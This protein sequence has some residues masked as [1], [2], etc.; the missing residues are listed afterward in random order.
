MAA[1]VLMFQGTGSD[2]GKSLVVAG[3]C[4]LLA[5]RG[6]SVRPFKP[7][8]MSNNAA[9]TEDGGE[10]G[11][12]QALQARAAR[13]A[14]SVDMNPVLLKPQSEVGAQIVVQGRVFG[15]AR[16]REY[17]S[18]KKELMPYVL[19]SFTKIRAQCDVVLVEGAGSAS[20]VNLRANDIANMGF[21]RAAD[22]PVVVI[23]DIDR[24]GVIASLCGTAAVVA[25]DD[26]KLIV[27]FIVN[28]MRGD[29]SLFSTGMTFVA[30]RTGWAPLGLVPYFRDAH[31]LPAED[32]FGLEVS[33]VR[34]SDNVGRRVRIVVPVLPHIA[35]F[36]DLDPLRLE[37]GV[38]LLLLRNGVPLPVDTDLLILP[39]SK[40]TIADLAALRACGW[41]ADI[42]AYAR[43]G[44]RVL[45]LCGGYQML[46]RS[47]ADPN[48][49][50]GPPGS[51][52]GLGLI[53]VTTELAGD[54]SLVAVKG[55]TV[56]DDI[57]VAGYEMHIGRTTGAGTQRPLL[58]L[59]DGRLDGA[60]SADGRVAGSYLH[61]FFAVDAQRAAWLARLGV[62][63]SSYAYE[64]LV[65][66]TLDAL[67]AHLAAHIDIDKMLSLAR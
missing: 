42:V 41:D 37:P 34:P 23:G 24:G 58:R 1:R 50:E 47:V 6:L 35:N 29:P 3:L 5:I 66:Q 54:K 15:N 56:A 64:E 32:V 7:Q 30:E 8:N 57:A 9:V 60:V 28:K 31:R 55:R 52:D 19:D 16:A 59:D 45:G 33:P 12:A 13:V 18:R 25:P 67:A 44:G 4:R 38:E 39:G 65:E 10:I 21:A 48:G 53:D 27:G 11:R 49:I 36:D 61:G 26:G 2:V 40:A 46:G 17:Q 63:A 20:E 22:V 62:P 43:R 14:P 51:A